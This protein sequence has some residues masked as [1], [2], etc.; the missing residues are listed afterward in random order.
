[1]DEQTQNL[2]AALEECCRTLTAPVAVR[3]ARPGEATPQKAKVPTEKLNKRLAVCQGM[4]LARTFGWTMA[5]R[6]G[7]H[8]CPLPRVFLGH[9]G[10]ERL[11]EGSLAE[12]YQDD[13][14]CMQAME[15]SYPRWPQDTYSEV[16]L[17][18]LATCGFVPDA[19]VVYG[20]PA[21]ILALVQGANYGKGT[22]VA[23]LSTGRYGCS[24]W[25]AGVV[26]SG[27]CTYLIP[28]PGERIFAG[29]QDHEMSFAVPHPK[30]QPLADGLRFVRSRGAYRYPV[31][32]L[33]VLAEP[34]LPPKYHSIDPERDG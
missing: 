17:A 4:T 9:I 10:A 18:P 2:A 27:E 8:G 26:Q 12:F 28:G 32:N 24:A 19:V 25:L 30:F 7:D 1:M 31:P 5:F 15:A 21:Q 11:L 34:Q 16:W 14:A 33:G 29:T 23:S 6:K 20:N 22:G 13:P 3:L